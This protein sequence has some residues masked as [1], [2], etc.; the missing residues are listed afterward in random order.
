MTTKPK[1]T[2]HTVKP[3]IKQKTSKG[4]AKSY[5]KKYKG[6]RY[7]QTFLKKH[8]SKRYKTLEE[9]RSRSKELIEDLRSQDQKV[10]TKNLFALE[11]ELFK[12]K[13]ADKKDSLI[14]PELPD[15]LSFPTH[16]FLLNDYPSFI[17]FLPKSLNL[18]F[19]SKIS[20][21]SLPNIEAGES[22]D[23]YDY[24]ADF[25]SYC[26]DLKS[27]SDSGTQY[28]L[29][30]FVVCNPPKWDAKLEKWVSDI[31][32]C[33]SDGSYFNY[34]FDTSNVEKRAHE[35]IISE[36][37]EEKPKEELKEAEKVITPTETIKLKEIE[38]KIKEQDTKVSLEKEKTKQERIKAVVELAKAGFN[39]DEI[40]ELLGL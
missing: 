20:S 24:F 21:D 34:G 7:I 13:R 12:I 28:S 36:E 38:L 31:I 14:A 32:S 39:K 3:K 6:L 15:T 4:K 23:Y 25:V 2:K 19:K 9:R 33:D 26:N 22:I 29:D 10:I 30:W 11:R 17:T 8:Y 27:K 5:K 1:K 18:V 35:T 16:Y 40:K 37:A